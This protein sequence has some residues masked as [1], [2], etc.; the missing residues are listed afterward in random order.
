MVAF[1]NVAEMVVRVEALLVELR[2]AA[3]GGVQADFQEFRLRRGL[4]QEPPRHEVPQAVNDQLLPAAELLG[5]LLLAGPLLLL[6]GP[7]PLRGVH[8]LD[9]LVGLLG[10]AARIA[11]GL[12]S[13]MVLAGDLEPRLLV[14]GH[15]QRPAAPIGADLDLHDV[16][17]FELLGAELGR[18][19]EVMAAR[20]VV[21]GPI[22]VQA[23]ADRRPG[24]VCGGIRRTTSAGPLAARSSA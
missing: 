20:L 3:A 15:S 11:S 2:P 9:G 6:L 12:F 17:S 16:Q 7:L 8:L 21:L 18:Q 24:R 5:D 10:A 19:A 14:L 22:A 1:Q 23:A 4:V 13:S